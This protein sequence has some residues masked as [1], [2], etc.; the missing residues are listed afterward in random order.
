MY[1]CR[2]V[3]WGLNAFRKNIDP[4][5]PALF[6]QADTSQIVITIFSKIENTVEN[7]E[8]DDC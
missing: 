2:P 5:K 3:K 6:E 7:G 8:T 4:C 1:K